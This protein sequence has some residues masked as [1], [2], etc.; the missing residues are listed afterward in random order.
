MTGNRRVLINATASAVQVV[1][2][3]AVLLVLYRYLLEVIGEEQAGVWALVLSW[4]SASSIASLGMAGGAVKFVSQYLARGDRDRV[5]EVVQTSVLSVAGFLLVVLL[6]LYPAFQGFLRVVVKPEARI[7]DALAVLPYALLSFWLSSL[8][9]VLQSCID[10]THRVYLRNLLIMAG[11]VVYLGL[12]LLL[13]P[14]RGLIGLAQAQ[15]LQAALLLAAAWIMLKRLLP[16]LP[17]VPFR[18]SRAAFKE[19][20]R[21][22]INFQVMSFWAMLLEPVTKALF[23]RFGGVGAVF[24]FEM[25]NKMVMQLRALLVTAHQSIVPAIAHLQ[26]TDAG[27]VQEVYRK[28][29]RLLVFLVAPFLPLMI[30]LTPVIS[31]LWIGAYEPL[32]VVSGVLLFLGWFLNILTNPAY[33]G[34]LGVGELRWNVRGHA[35]I[36]VLNVALG[37]GLGLLFGAAGVVVGFVVALAAGSLL[38]LLAYHRDYGIRAGE[39]LQRQSLGVGAAG[40]AGMGLSILLYAQLKEAV[41]PALLAL[42]QIA[43]YLTVVFLPVWRHPLRLQL[44]QWVTHSL[45]QKAEP[46]GS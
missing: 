5:L 20:F 28:S 12:T 44:Q 24:F 9:G 8:A 30:S 2:N 46:S 39:L 32:F 43:A 22:G 16:S 35:A 18:W 41:P 23:S 31:R 37:G 17:V 40:L 4:T 27:Q 25:A 36:G 14:E 10:G 3:A 13:V 21:Y 29:F 1:V 15:A 42:L 6:A 38:I 26:E 11:A 7:P 45:F 19:M 34:Y 33:F